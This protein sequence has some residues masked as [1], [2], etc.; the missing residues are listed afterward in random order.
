MSTEQG[1]GMVIVLLLFW[2]GLHAFHE[3]EVHQATLE[4]VLSENPATL[5]LRHTALK[6]LTTASLQS[7]G[8]NES[9]DLTMR[10]LAWEELAA[11]KK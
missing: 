5:E 2:L 10:T 6:T 9:F 11:R 8:F 1:F 4:F 7:L 3:Y